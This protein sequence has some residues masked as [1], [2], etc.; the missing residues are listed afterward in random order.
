MLAMLRSLTTTKPL[1]FY[2]ITTQEETVVAR[3]LYRTSGVIS[4]LLP[5]VR[6]LA[7]TSRQLRRDASLLQGGQLALLTPFPPHSSIFNV[8]VSLDETPLRSSFTGLRSKCHLPSCCPCNVRAM[9]PRPVSSPAWTTPAAQTHASRIELAA[10]P[11]PAPWA[12]AAGRDAQKAT[13]AKRAAAALVSAP[14]A[15]LRGVTRAPG[16]VRS[17]V[18]HARSPVKTRA[19]TRAAA[20]AAAAP[21]PPKPAPKEAAAKAGGAKGRRTRSQTSNADALESHG[22]KTIGPSAALGGARTGRSPAPFHASLGRL[23][24]RGEKRG[25]AHGRAGVTVRR[26]L[27][28]QLR[29]AP[30]RRS[31]ARA[32]LRPASRSPSRPSTLASAPGRLTSLSCE[33]A[34][35]RSSRFSSTA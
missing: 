27:R 10:S 2:D 15:L 28:A 25:W 32:P 26:A 23:H 4:F 5:S 11:P 29:R 7:S 6:F 9:A 33:I 35:S 24:R 16:R 18:S 21:A 20:A 30:S 17:A 3:G 8:P 22:Y 19:A 31:C 14:L 13:F 34:S 1:S 12:P